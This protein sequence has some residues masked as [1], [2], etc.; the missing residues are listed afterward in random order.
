MNIV[1][2]G[3]CGFIGSHIVDKLVALEHKVTVVDNLS[4]NNDRFYYNDEADYRPIDIND[5]DALGRNLKDVDCIFHLAA[6]SRI[7]PCVENPLLAAKTNL[8]GTCNLLQF[9]RQNSVK[10]FIY[11]STSSAYGLNSS[12]QVE[13]MHRDCL[14][15]YSVTKVG[16]EDLCKM[17]YTLFSLPTITFRYFN[18]YGDRQPKKGQYAP[19]IGIFQRQ[20]AA[21]EKLTIVGDGEQRRDFIN[22]HDIVEANILAMNTQNKKCFGEV[23][24]IGT[25]VNWSVK[26]I[27]DLI[28]PKQVHLPERPGE[29]RETLADITKARTMLNFNP[30]HKVDE[31][32]KSRL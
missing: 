19:V 7:G 8:V 17:Y 1:V 15:P 6:E 10:R 13:T 25:G 20:H 14:N 3:G 31:W 9:A 22:V 26:E 11:S 23:F 5:F 12:P 21:G 4:A 18:V 32:I 27:A 29:A 30:T 2:T 16:A 28:S 24:N